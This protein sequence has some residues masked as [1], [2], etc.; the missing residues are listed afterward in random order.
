MAN[1]REYEVTSPDGRTFTVT[2]PANASQ[3]EVLAYAQQQFNSAR[4]TDPT[5][6]NAARMFGQGVTLG[7]GDEIEAG[8]RAPF[9]D[10]S[11]R[12]IRDDIRSNIAGF[13]QENP[14]SALALEVGGGFALPFGALKAVGTTGR[15]ALTGPTALETAKTGFKLGA[16]TGAIAG[17]GGAAEMLDVPLDAA[18]GAG[19]GGPLGAA[20]PVAVNTVGG[21]ARRVYDALGIGGKQR[22][23]T[24][25]ERKMIEALQRDGFTPEQ[26]A[27]RLR[28]GRDLG[29]SDMLIADLGPNSQGLGYSATSVP[30][31]ARTDVQNRLFGRAQDEASNIAAQVQRR[32]GLNSDQMLGTSYIDDLAERQARAA[33]Q[34]YPEAYKIAVDANPFR[35]YVGREVVERAYEQARRLADVDGV[36]LPPFAEIK[37]A[38]S[39]PTEVMHQ[40]KRGL[41]QIVAKETDALTG[42][43]TPFGGA[44]SKLTKEIN[45]K[46]KELNP[47]YAKANRE[48]AD[49]QRLQNS[50]KEGLDYLKMSENDLVKK[51]KGMNAG[52]REAFRV[53]L[54]SKVQERANTLD[55]STDFTKAVFGS[56][57]KRSALRYA[58]DNEDQFKAFTNV[59]DMQRAMRQTN[60]RVLG[61]SPT[62]GR[63]TQMDDAGRDPTTM[64]NMARNL[65]QGNVSQAALGFA[66]N[67]GAR[68]G[69]LNEQSAEMLARRMFSAAPG[70]QQQIL[71]EL[72]SRASKENQA[73]INSVMRNP[74]MYSVPAAGQGG[75]LMSE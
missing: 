1:T 2:A 62:A 54:V 65:A 44:V 16:G 72:A 29:V 13:R 69:G 24:F 58:F 30:N 4:Q 75:L 46:L 21:F 40:L 23:L 60:N 57:K 59:I 35:P 43:M 50:Y 55:D 73:R 74:A 45:D 5:G 27:Q 70:R 26:A 7:F 41:D 68:S 3:D 47:L 49:S 20:T 39:I 15:A 14:G 56:P 38:Q 66:G 63:L 22:A 48:F 34:A 37:N 19:I 53:G 64:I 6:V 52:E 36:T 51:L 61:G 9:S 42:K 12:D 25:A 8:V 71:N 17:A 18:V 11:Y 67:L 31:R 33:R 28:E 32:S 10:R